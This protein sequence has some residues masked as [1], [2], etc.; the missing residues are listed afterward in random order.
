MLLA[1]H[2]YRGK[3]YPI[4]KPRRLPRGRAGLGETGKYQSYFTLALGGLLALRLV[5]DPLPLLLLDQEIYLRT[6]GRV[7]PPFPDDLA[8]QYLP[9]GFLLR[10][11]STASYRSYYD[12]YLHLERRH[13]AVARLQKEDFIE[14]ENLPA[15]LA[16]S[17]LVDYVSSIALRLVE[18]AAT[19]T[20]IHYEI[21]D[22]DFYTSAGQM[23]RKRSWSSPEFAPFKATVEDYNL[24]LGDEYV[25]LKM[26]AGKM[27]LWEHS[28][29]LT[30]AEIDGIK[31]IL[32]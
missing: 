18:V 29:A 9:E 6:D 13:P 30:P 19:I 8:A 23:H 32:Y 17:H 7:P 31:L 15:I 26:I 5:Q 27:Y 10:Y 2:S 4:S 21:Q 3:V 14:M 1:S 25:S 20:A 12:Y 28:R 22:R 16:Q 11:Q 24:P